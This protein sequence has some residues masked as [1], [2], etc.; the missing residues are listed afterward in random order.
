MSP[1]AWTKN[2]TKYKKYINPNGSVNVIHFSPGKKKVSIRVPKTNASNVPAFLRKYYTRLPPLLLG[3]AVHYS[4]KI[5]KLS[6][7]WMKTAGETIEAGNMK[8]NNFWQNSTVNGRTGTALTTLNKTELRTIYNVTKG[9]KTVRKGIA[10]LGGGEQAVVYLGYYDKACKHPVSLKVFPLDKAF[11]VNKQPA[12]TE[13]KIGEKVHKVVP[14]H[15]PK[16]IAM[17]RT[18]GF[19]PESNLIRLSGPMNIRNQIVI[20]TEYFHGGDLR[21]W[22]N[23]VGSRLD[24]NTLIDI[25]RQVL[26]TLVKIQSVYPEFRHNDLHLGNVFIDDTGNRPRAAIADFGLAR[27][28]KT[29]SNP[30]VNK[31]FFLKNGLGPETSSRY[32]AH[33]FLNSMWSFASKYPRVKQFLE[34]VLPVG[35]RGRD[36]TY[37]K[38]SRL[39]YGM[40]LPGLPSTKEMLEKLQEKPKG[41]FKLT[42]SKMLKP[43]PK[44]TDAA[45]IALQ[46]LQGVQGVSV[47]ATNFLKLSPKSRAAMMKPGQKKKPATLQFKKTEGN[48]TASKK[49]NVGAF[50]KILLEKKPFKTPPRPAKNI[51]NSATQNKNVNSLTVRNLRTILERYSYS[52]V[53]A[54]REARAWT[55]AWVSRVTK[56]RQNLK[57]TQGNNGRVRAGKKLLMGHKKDELVAMAKKHG[58]KTNGKTKDQLIKSLWSM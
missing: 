43:V 35:Y 9:V 51:L 47:S 17:E 10:K 13:F 49:T 42:S 48:A 12:E 41:T 32:D 46:A 14:T 22:M 16:Y 25:I 50:V 38:E 5:A 6:P 3:Q 30:I 56:R 55:N 1:P 57:L 2:K 4:P 39:K 11:P 24:E 21:S 28:T 8:A 26:S 15:T 29:I 58:L 44:N 18:K 19:V 53:N 34:S 23:K 31:G 52:K 37:V 54:K 33:L 20:L 36:D 45:N 40:E 27:L 7:N